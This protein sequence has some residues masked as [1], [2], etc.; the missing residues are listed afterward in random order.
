MRF[1]NHTLEGGIST[2][3]GV[4]SASMPSTVPLVNHS[5]QAVSSLTHHFYRSITSSL[6][7]TAGHRLVRYQV[8]QASI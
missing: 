8:R 4:L 2:K 6:Q 1:G 7:P 3:A 5:W